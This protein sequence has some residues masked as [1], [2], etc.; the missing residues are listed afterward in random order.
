MLLADA[1][2]ANRLG[3]L[4]RRPVVVPLNPVQEDGELAWNTAS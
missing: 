3:H 1:V 2:A 4:Q